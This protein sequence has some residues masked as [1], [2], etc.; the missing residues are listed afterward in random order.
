MARK[1]QD[2]DHHQQGR[3]PMSL[4]K[5]IQYIT[6]IKFKMGVTL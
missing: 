2:R 4:K 3:K 6:S 5:L 1:I